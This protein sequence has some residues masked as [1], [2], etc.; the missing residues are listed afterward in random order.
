MLSTYLGYRMYTQDLTRSLVRTASQ[1]DVAREEA[2]Y[3][4]NIGKAKSVDD[5][6]NDRRLFAYAM[7]AH[8]LEDMT[9]AKAF[10]RKILL[11]DV[12]DSKSFARQLVDPRYVAFARAFSFTTEGSVKASLPYVQNEFQE[13]DTIGLYS[14]QR[15]RKGATAATETDYFKAKL[16]TLTSVD[17]LIDDDRLFSY[18][19][20]AHGLDPRYAS[21]STI[22]DVLTSDLSDPNS[23]A[24]TLGDARYVKLAQ[25]FDFETDGS[26]TTGSTAQSDAQLNGTINAYY[27]ATGS[28]ASPAAASFRTTYYTAAIGSVTSV[29]DLLN[30]DLLYN[31]ALIAYGLNPTLQS[32][33][34]IRQ[35]LTSDLSDPNSFANTQTDNRYRLLAEAFN[36]ATDGTIA[37]TDGA[38]SADQVDGTTE[39]YLAHYDDAAVNAETVATNFYRSRINTLI[40]VDE[41]IKN[42]TLYNYVLEAYGF[43][44]KVESKSK[45]RQ[46]L[47][48]DSTDPAS[49]ANRQRDKRYRELAADFNFGSDGSVLQPREA[50]SET[51]E[52]ATINLYNSRVGSSASEDAAAQKEST[53]YHNAIIRIRSLDDFL[54]D[55]RLVAYVLKAHGFEGETV[56]NDELRKVLTSDPFDE[57]SYV[58]K[59]SDTRFRG[60]AAAFNFT[61]DGQ[62]GRGPDQ[63]VQ[64]RS[65]ML[66]TMD[67]HVRQ[68]MEAEAGAQNEGVRLALYFQR[69]APE[70]TS[71]LSI[72]ADKALFEVAR[73]ALGL[74]ESMS[75]ADIDLQAAMINKRLNIED[76]K[77][78][79]KLDKFLARFTTLYDLNSGTS[80]A[81]SPASILLGGGGTNV[82][83]DVSLLSRLQSITRGRL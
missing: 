56:T 53:Y 46:V 40:S 9:Y 71:A 57:D 67:L 78:P 55:K 38:Q 21:T 80:S 42:A 76:L 73:T 13:D 83:T 43:D 47:T 23:V 61:A 82:G 35:V 70:I 51:E 66:K 31:Y 3:Q 5:F 8:G 49:F 81:A 48:S 6:L 25:A 33:D 17:Q 26:V 2:Y 19:L 12:N 15:V 28:G 62:I 1:V 16:A 27:D 63:Q 59:L 65:A 41:L 11:S 36:F 60:M 10:M 44:P 72:L 68:S 69:K 34:T 14:E 77:D 50:Q 74:P 54:K 4:D 45:I 58:S 30:D 75:Q 7:K 37:G 22:R 20:T 52:L 29:D 18:A 32:K 79:E 39:L 24:N 64:S